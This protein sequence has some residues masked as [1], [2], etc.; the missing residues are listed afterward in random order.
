MVS[1]TAHERRKELM[2]SEQLPTPLVE[3]SW[4]SSQLDDP[5]LRILECTVFLGPPRQIGEQW[6]AE[7][8]RA[9]WAKRHIP[10]SGFADL[11]YALSDPASPFPFMLPPTEKFTDEMERLG[12]GEGVKVVLYDRAYNMWAARLWWMLR[13]FG[14]DDASVLNGGWKKWTSDGYPSSMDTPTF[15]RGHFVPRPRP[16][17]FATKEEVLASIKDGHTCLINALQPEQY[18]GQEPS[19]YARSGRIPSSVNVPAS[20]LVNPVNHSYLPLD[21]LRALV[22]TVAVGA[23]QGDR[24][25][26]YCGAGIA[27]SS[28]A[29]ILTMLG[30]PQVAVYDGSLSEWSADLALP[31][32]SGM[33]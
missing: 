29:L 7:S 13:A 25:I 19:G 30:F 28:D 3:T 27:A 5:N 16:E 15:P 23:T 20:A 10:G 9:A 1:Y 21:Q 4:L 18:D 17:L 12:V 22:S 11:L 24:V 6:T 31:M 8:G 2:I 33:V 32:E 26:T 14:F